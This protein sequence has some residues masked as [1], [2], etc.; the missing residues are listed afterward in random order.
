MSTPQHSRAPGWGGA[1]K[2]NWSKS[3]AP[4]AHWCVTWLHVIARDAPMGRSHVGFGNH[5][6]LFVSVVI[7]CKPVT[8]KLQAV[9]RLPHPLLE[10][11][12]SLEY[13]KGWQNPGILIR[14][15]QRVRV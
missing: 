15:M 7:C 5:Y 3:Q 11:S 2:K 8:Q 6:N 1:V 14:V 10:L 4:M 13:N 12:S 9:P